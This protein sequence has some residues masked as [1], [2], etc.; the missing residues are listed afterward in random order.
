MLAV[1]F[2]MLESAHPE[3]LTGLREAGVDLHAFFSIKDSDVHDLLGEKGLKV[4][5][6]AKRNEA[7]QRARREGDFMAKHKIK[8]ISLLDEVYPPN[9]AAQVD[10]PIVLYVLGSSDIDSPHNIGIVG[11]RKM[12]SYGASFTSKIVADLAPHYD[13][14]CVVSG[15]AY[16]V[17]A[18]AHKA[19]LDADRNTI[20]VVA[21]GLDTIYPA[22][23]R[24]LAR[25]IIRSGG[26]IV[27]EYPSGVR[28]Y[29]NNFLA[30]NRIVAYISK[31]LIVVESPLKGGAMSTARYAFEGGL[32]VFALPGRISD[33][34]SQGCNQLIQSQRASLMTGAS[35]ITELYGWTP[36]ESSHS[37]QKSIFPEI[38]GDTAIIY[39]FL[40]RE[41]EPCHIDQIRV[42]TELAMPKVMAALS[43][44][45]FDGIVIRHPGNRFSIAP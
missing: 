24:D 29:R 20:G 6:E 19:A 43:E 1:A 28:P 5:N 22:A 32:P 11:T 30:R 18:A 25:S 3:I 35:D 38:T 21:H 10:P 33:E 12:T 26:A 27:S 31:A 39:T 8:C 14:L 9:M 37:V 45:E 42:F 4:F 2:S 40:K 17:D 15:L 23:H 16:G 13:D 34:C 36:K 7:L 41:S 44:M